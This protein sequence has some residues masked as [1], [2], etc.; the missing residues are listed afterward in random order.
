MDLRKGDNGS[1]DMYFGPGAPVGFGKNWIPTIDGKGWFTHFRLYGPV[2]T[3][4]D[5]S[6]KLP[7]IE[8][9]K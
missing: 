6:W 5:A 4:L 9:V 7:D 8:M 1:V 3:Y 2:E